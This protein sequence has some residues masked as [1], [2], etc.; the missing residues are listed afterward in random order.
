MNI[1]LTWLKCY[2]RADAFP[3]L[4]FRLD[5]KFKVA[6]E[7]FSDGQFFVK[8]VKCPIADD[9]NIP[10]VRFLRLWFEF[11]DC[12]FLLFLQ[13]WGLTGGQMGSQEGMGLAGVRWPLTLS[14]YLKIGRRWVQWAGI[15]DHCTGWFLWCFIMISR[16]AD[17]KVAV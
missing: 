12:F 16:E 14:K 7:C 3:L 9:G 17:S 6:E 1:H 13:D 10:W 11:T 2:I 8:L 15:D 4:R 5:M